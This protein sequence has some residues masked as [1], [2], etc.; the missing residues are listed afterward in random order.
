[1]SNGSLTSHHPARPSRL[2]KKPTKAMAESNCA[3][4]TSR[5]ILGGFRS[6]TPGRACRA[7]PASLNFSQFVE[8][9]RWWPWAREDLAVA[10]VLVGAEPYRGE[11]IRSGHGECLAV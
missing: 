11:E 10:R 8:G 9:Q 1:M 4:A 6:N 5:P 3:G 7:L 2:T